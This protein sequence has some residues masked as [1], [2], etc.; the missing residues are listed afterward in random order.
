MRLQ[1]IIGISI[2]L[3]SC[4]PSK[5]DVQKEKK[6]VEDSISVVRENEKR[7]LEAEKLHLE[8]IEAGK[9]LKAQKLI[10]IHLALQSQLNS[11][12]EELKRINIFQIGRSQDTKDRQIA[13]QNREIL[14]ISRLITT[15]KEAEIKARIQ[16]KFDFQ[17]NPKTLAEAL[18]N[19]A[20]TNEFEKLPNFLDPY[21]E[22]DKEI[23]GL[24]YAHL[25]EDGIQEFVSIFRNARIINEYQYGPK[26]AGIEMAIGPSSDLLRT[27]KFVKRMDLWYLTSI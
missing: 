6:R 24:C 1:L 23:F 14:K 19:I 20:S 7:K 18:I 21:G 22:Y 17:K 5:E 8:K 2:V 12:E 27:V 4:G 10:D 16:E 15:V 9:A 25:S 3:L 13:N 11:A 26:S